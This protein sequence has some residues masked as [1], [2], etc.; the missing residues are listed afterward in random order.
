VY[1]YWLVAVAFPTGELWFRIGIKERCRDMFAYFQQQIMNYMQ[2][3]ELIC[4]SE[5]DEKLDAFSEIMRNRHN[6]RKRKIPNQVFHSIIMKDY[7]NERSTYSAQQ[8]RRR[9]RIS[10]EVAREVMLILRANNSYFMQKK[11]IVRTVNPCIW[12]HS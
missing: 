8:F 5:D 7:F 10:Q 11:R 6:E 2:F 1:L 12:L 9:F 4:S 3:S